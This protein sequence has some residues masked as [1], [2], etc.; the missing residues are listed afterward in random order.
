MVKF[1]LRIDGNTYEKLQAA[2]TKSHR[3]INGLVNYLI[4]EFLKKEV[5]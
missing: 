1:L 3:S 2:A 4:E 5:E